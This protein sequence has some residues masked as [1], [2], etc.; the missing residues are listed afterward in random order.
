MKRFY[1]IILLLL[2]TCLFISW[3][4]VQAACSID[5]L[6]SGGGLISFDQ[7]G[8]M[9]S[10]G[11]EVYVL[12]ELASE[13]KVIDANQRMVTATVSGL[14]DPFAL[15]LDQSGQRVFVSSF[16]NQVQSI[17]VSATESSSYQVTRD[18][19]VSSAALGPLAV[20]NDLLWLVTDHVT[21]S[22]ILIR[23]TSDLSEATS[24]ISGNSQLQAPS[25]ALVI[26]NYLYVSFNASSRIGVYDLTTSTLLTT[27]TVDSG[28]TALSLAPDGLT[29]YAANTSAGTISVINTQTNS[30]TKTIDNPNLLSKPRALAWLNGRLWIANQDSG[31]LVQYD[32][33]IADLLS[34]TCDGGLVA[35]KYLLAVQD[36]L[37]VSHKNGVSVISDTDQLKAQV[38]QGNAVEYSSVLGSI[39][40]TQSEV[41]DLRIEG[42]S[43][44]FDILGSGGLQAGAT[45]DRSWQMTAP[46]LIDTHTFSIQ[47][48]GSGNSLT[49]AVRVG[50]ELGVSPSGPL[51][52]ELDG[53]SV[54]LTASGGFPP[55]N[56]SS[57]QGL[58]SATS[59]RYVVYTPRTSGSDSVVLRDSMDA[60][61][62]IAMTVNVSGLNVSPA[63]AVMLAGESRDFLAI[64]SSNISWDSPLGGSLSSNSG[65]LVSWT[66]PTEIGE[67][68]LQLS[69]SQT[70]QN[71]QAVIFV[72]QD[73]LNISPAERTLSTQGNEIFQASGGRGP[74]TWSSQQGDLSATEGSAITYIA[75]DASVNDTVTVQDSG[76]RIAVA[77]ISVRGSLQISPLTTVAERGEILN[78]SL[79]QSSG[80]VDWQAQDGSLSNTSGNAASYTSPDRTGRFVVSAIDSSGQLAQAVVFVVS[81]SLSTSPSSASLAPQASTLLSVQGGIAPYIWSARAGTL[82]A[83]EGAAVLFTAPEQVSDTPVTITVEDGLGNLAVARMQISTSDALMQ[84]YDSDNNGVLS[85]PELY[86]ATQDFLNQQLDATDMQTLVEQFFSHH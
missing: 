34:Q 72:I 67:Y 84:A 13:L 52:L 11:N 4:G 39:I 22:E 12:D 32:P 68:S 61:K 19:M 29:L 3:Q 5:D 40:S 56:W 69:D 35:P 17:D 65:S 75:P 20:F 83:S 9:L 16:M 78:F 66:A 26:G 48:L 54:L 33:G 27:I 36:V 28:V 62:I 85:R 81:D 14:D 42:G 23:N 43:G 31:T 86:R 80:S 76:G 58:L 77:R 71:A 82:S 53:Q 45:G 15:T 8:A 38:R 70:A 44:P 74:Y 21:G 25:Q 64:G 55:Y 1:H 24:P 79:S 2:S 60:A 37:F 57:G 18:V 73:E 46:A 50:G 47:D 30:V 10:D 7:P 49:L 6:S 51:T 59:G 63:V 41:F